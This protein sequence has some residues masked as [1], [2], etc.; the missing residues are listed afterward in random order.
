MIHLVFCAVIVLGVFLLCRVPSMQARPALCHGLW[1][2]VL[3]RFVVPPLVLVPIPSRAPAVAIAEPSTVSQNAVLPRAS[4]EVLMSD[5]DNDQAIAPPAVS[6]TNTVPTEV[7]SVAAKPR[8]SRIETTRASVSIP[9]VLAVIS[10]TGTMVIWFLMI[11]SFRRLNRILA[12][13]KDALAAEQEVL[14]RLVSRLQLQR[15]P[16][17]VL[18]DATVSPMLWI[19]QRAKA[20]IVVPRQLM[21]SLN[22]DELEH[23]LAHEL[24]HWRRCDHW[25][26]LFASIIVSLFWWNPF[27]WLAR[28]EMMAAAEA[29]CDALAVRDCGG[30]RKSY[31]STLLRVSDFIQHDQPSLR[32]V[33]T[34]FGG[35]HAMTLR[36]R[37]LCDS[38]VASG[39]SRKGRGLLV[40][41][42]GVLLMMPVRSQE[43]LPQA[44]SA[45]A[46]AGSS[47]KVEGSVVELSALDRPDVERPN[48]ELSGAARDRIAVLGEE[49][50]RMA[51]L[52]WK[53]VVDAAARLIYVPDDQGK[54]SVYS[55][56]S[57]LRLRTFPLHD[58]R[59]LDVVVLDQGRQ[60]LSISLDGTLRLWDITADQPKQLDVIQLAPEGQW[61]EM[62]SSRDGTR[63]AV[64]LDKEIVLF[65]VVTGKLIRREVFSKENHIPASEARPFERLYEF[66]IS[67]DGHWLAINELNE[68]SNETSTGPFFPED[69]PTSVDAKLILRDLSCS[70]ALSK[71]TC[72]V[73]GKDITQ[74]NFS[75]DSKRLHAM[76]S[77]GKRK[78]HSWS[79]ADGELVKLADT[80]LTS[81]PT[82]VFGFPFIEQGPLKASFAGT[83]ITVTEATPDGVRSRGVIELNEAIVLAAAFVGND[84]ILA[85]GPTLRRCEWVD[86]QYRFSRSYD[87]H[88]SWVRS[89]H[90]DQSSETLISGSDDSIFAWD[91]S[92]LHI[93][94]PSTATRLPWKGELIPW[95]ATNGFVVRRTLKPA[96]VTANETHIRENLVGLSRSKDGDFSERFSLTIEATSESESVWSIA[97][98]PTEAIMAMGHH[99]GQIRLWDV[100]TKEPVKLSEWDTEGG[101]VCS[102]AFSPDGTQLA[103]AG[104]DHK[105]RLWNIELADTRKGIQSSGANIGSH[106]RKARKVAWSPDGQWLASGG[107]DGQ[108]LLF[109]M[110][111]G[112]ASPPAVLFLDRNTMPEASYVF[113]ETIKSLEFSRDGKRLLSADSIGRVRLWSTTSATVLKQWRFPPPL[114]RF[115]PDETMIAVAHSIGLIELLRVPAD[116]GEDHDNT[117]KP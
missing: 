5:V 27:A 93:A 77:T 108:I 20:V 91:L 23:V 59:C 10:V 70:G 51:G 47:V 41:A 56:E 87:G 58:K 14:Q 115:S 7:P 55:A 38:R 69:G 107:A 37:S 21:G 98:H 83:Q 95:N 105:I 85:S 53:L 74:L 49:Q 103:S 34:T 2:L 116:S 6:I 32:L 64:Q 61:L 16:R 75:Q 33:G 73:I 24:A 68:T 39:I 96:Q 12:R 110:N 57:L 82:S 88:Q 4:E 71:V 11:R 19:A 101:N 44:S 92:R 45:S 35:T 79:V 40:A 67:P 97:M 29:S 84:L 30:F 50:G 102:V 3:L 117:K 72:E 106:T 66:A 1:C 13:A 28:R 113:R 46:K 54:V 86:G 31:A 109:E 43:T 104:E 89:L 9:V 52:T 111:N 18:V 62:R 81:E 90:F 36:F 112:N 15:S 78:L 22:S 48:A 114:A 76:P 63:L 25:T 17:V 80:D 26:S 65:D 99:G 100:S 8:P 60:L 42:V 94:L